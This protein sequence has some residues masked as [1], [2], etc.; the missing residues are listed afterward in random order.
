[1]QALRWLSDN[2]AMSTG[3]DEA[4]ELYEDWRAADAL[5]RAAERNVVNGVLRAIDTRGD[6][7]QVQTWDQARSLRKNADAASHRLM[8]LGRRQR[9]SP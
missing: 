1:M 3:V 5:A 7:P 9:G 8:D 4:K 6:P 2:P